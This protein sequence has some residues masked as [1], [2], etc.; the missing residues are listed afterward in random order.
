MTHG[1]DPF[2]L[3][4]GDNCG[5][6]VAHHGD[7]HVEQHNRQHD[8]EHQEHEFGEGCVDVLAHPGVLKDNVIVSIQVSTVNFN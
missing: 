6:S 7:E 3:G 1:L 2:F 8:G 5:V 4:I